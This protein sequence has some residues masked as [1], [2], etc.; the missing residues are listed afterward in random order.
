MEPAEKEVIGHV[1]LVPALGED[2]GQQQ[3]VP[4]SDGLQVA[5]S[6]TAPECVGFD[7]AA[8][9]I[10]SPEQTLDGSFAA[11]PP[12]SPSW[13]RRKKTLAMIVTVVVAVVVGLG[14]GLG[15]GLRP[16]KKDGGPSDD[17]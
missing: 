5:H 13:W 16:S 14:V 11:A 10:L 4:Y 3:A 9:K 6:P 1:H 17:R 12:S 8:S 15:V 2:K 7:C